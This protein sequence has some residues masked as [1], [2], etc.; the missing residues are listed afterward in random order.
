MEL[1]YPGHHNDTTL[2]TTG[3]AVPS[4]LGN[5]GVIRASQAAPGPSN[6]PIGSPGGLA[7]TPNEEKF[8]EYTPGSSP[9]PEPEHKP[10]PE[11]LNIIQSPNGTLRTE[12]RGELDEDLGNFHK[13]K[14]I[15]VSTAFPISQRD[16]IQ[17]IAKIKY[18]DS[19]GKRPRSVVV[20]PTC[21]KNEPIAIRNY[22]KVSNKYDQF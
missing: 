17:N 20:R 4:A 13:P 18:H 2:L 15:C 22:F 3:G 12:A 21:L 14:N 1:K 7:Y 16:Q 5:A 9:E 6:Q 10:D 19:P 8:T 11:A